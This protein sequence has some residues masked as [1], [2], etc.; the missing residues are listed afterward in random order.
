MFKKHKFYESIKKVHDNAKEDL[1]L[2]KQ[3]LEKETNELKEVKERL[4]KF[5]MTYSGTLGM[6]PI[7]VRDL[8]IEK[9]LLFLK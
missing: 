5:N 2:L 6:S 8:L 7:P 9:L 1:V 4:E 3:Q